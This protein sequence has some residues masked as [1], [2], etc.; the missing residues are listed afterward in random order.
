MNTGIIK[1]GHTLRCLTCGHARVV[2]KPWVREVCERYLARN[3]AFALYRSDLGRF[4]C[5]RC[6]S[7]TI[8]YVS[9]KYICRTKAIL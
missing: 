3:G 5:T 7:K 6:G 4:R 8:T 9:N 1:E 2:T